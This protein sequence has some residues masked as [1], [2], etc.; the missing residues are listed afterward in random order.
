MRT[1]ATQLV[2]TESGCEPKTLQL[3]N[4]VRLKTDR[5]FG[6]IWNGAHSQ[7]FPECWG[8]SASA[9]N[10]PSPAFLDEMSASFDWKGPWKHPVGLTG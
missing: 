3:K 5:S 4:N 7:S 2:G 10:H 9:R 6:A 8:Q 1:Q